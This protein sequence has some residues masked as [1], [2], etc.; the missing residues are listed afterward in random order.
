MNYTVIDVENWSRRDLF[1]L[2]TTDLRIVMNLT[3]KIDVTNL[4]AFTKHHNL[5]FYPVMIW[6]VSKLMNARDEFKYS[7]RPDGTL[8]RWNTISPSYTDFDPA[9]ETFNKF[10]TEYCDDVF[11]FCERVAA[12]REKYKGQVGFMPN[13]PENVFDISCLPWTHYSSLDLHIYHD[14][15]ALFPIV[16][17]GKYEPH[18]GKIELPV[19]MLFHHAC[20]DGFHLS[21]FFGEL[22]QLLDQ[23]A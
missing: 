1:K 5:K 17:W 13:Q 2:Y 15:K 6:A 23:L 7:L 16:I 3:V 22:Q 12:D 21:R 14:G 18:D 11:T 10:V 19:T 4:L 8:I 9:T 20:G